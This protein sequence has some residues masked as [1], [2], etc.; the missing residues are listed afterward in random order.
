MALSLKLEHHTFLQESYG[1][2]RLPGEQ[3]PRT[4]VALSVLTDR[5]INEVKVLMDDINKSYRST[6]RKMAGQ[7]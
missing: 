2:P 5:P 7:E 4:I 1:K 3:D 6:F